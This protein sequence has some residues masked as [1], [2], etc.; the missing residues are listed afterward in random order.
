MSVKKITFKLKMITIF[1]CLFAGL[2]WP[3]LPIL[4]WSHYKLEKSLTS[5]SIDLEATTIDVISYNILTMIGGFFIPLISIIF[6]NLK[7][8]LTVNIFIFLE[9]KLKRIITKQYII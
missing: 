4:G 7:L 2:I 8:I 9:N 5:C 3:L 1:L 6:S